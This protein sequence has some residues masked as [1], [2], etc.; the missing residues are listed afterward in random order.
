MDLGKRKLWLCGMTCAGNL[1][2]LK[3][4][5]EPALEFV[6]GLQMTFHYPIDQ[7]WE[8]LDGVKG[9]GRI[10][11]AYWSMRHFNSMNQYLW[12]GTIQPGDFCLQIDDKE[13]ITS[14][15][16]Y[17]KLPLYLALM[18]EADVAVVAN[19]GKPLIYRYNESLEF[20][21]S[22]HWFLR[23]IDG[24]AINQELGNEYFANVRNAQRDEYQWVTH[25]ARYMI[26]YPAGSNHAL[27]GLDTYGDPNVLFPIR[28]QRRLEFRNL[29]RERGYELTVDG[30]VRMMK[31][32]DL[33]SDEKLR[34]YINNEKAF[35]DANQYLVLGNKNVVHSH[36]PKYIIKV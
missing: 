22:P 11:C 30:F 35:S 15:F 13:R 29:M 32:S 20:A 34:D 33:V 18:D 4:L 16:F 9:E 10:V 24:R 8:Y 17:E 5:V 31:E 3:A 7:G 12:Q 2:N 26:S 27:L 1:D 36:D 25:Y 21:G 6:N 28:E 23:G 19:F 14:K